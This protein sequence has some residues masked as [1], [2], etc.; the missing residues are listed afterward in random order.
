MNTAVRMICVTLVMLSSSGLLARVPALVQSAQCQDWT[1]YPTKY[2]CSFKHATTVGNSIIAFALV[3]GGPYVLV[4]GITDDH[5]PASNPY[6]EDLHYLFGDAQN[7]YFYSSS[8]TGSTRTITVTA[9]E[10]THFQVVLMEVSGLSS[11]QVKDQN[12]AY[13]NG[14]NTGQKFTSGLTRQTTQANEFLVGWSEQA[15]P[16]VMTFTD[17][18]PWILVEQEPIGGSRIVYRTTTT[19]DAF[20]YT[21]NFTGP[22]DYRVGA[23]IVTYKAADHE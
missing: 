10:S 18:P 23:A 8:A 3:S 20:E 11:G 7:I 2:R 15:Y 5:K 19:P 13:D 21:G 4:T 22:G 16:N 12:S 9:S 1:N 17:D 6:A 14:Y